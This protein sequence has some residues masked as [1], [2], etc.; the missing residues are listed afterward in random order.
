MSSQYGSTDLPRYWITL[1]GEIIF[2][3]P[4]QFV[5]KDKNGSFVK[6]LKGEKIYYPY[7]TDIRYFRVIA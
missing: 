6:N 2:D 4:K 1:D 7:Q 3:Y 5:E